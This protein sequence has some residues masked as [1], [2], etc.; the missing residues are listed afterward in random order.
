M[1]V[2]YRVSPLT[3]HAGGRWLVKARTF[4]LVNLLAKQTTA[5]TVA[6]AGGHIVPE[7][8]PWIGPTD[9]V[10]ELAIRMLRNPSE[11][12]AQREQLDQLIRTLDHPGASTRVAQLA[13]EMIG[14]KRS[15][16]NA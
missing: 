3:W 10:A 11:L 4:A 9:E 5:E 16:S 14:T 8:V 15:V 7:Y 13:L 1:I 6:A 12:Q 2:V